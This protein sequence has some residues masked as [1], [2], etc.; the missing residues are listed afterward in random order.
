[1]NVFTGV[2][3][4]I[5]IQSVK[6]KKFSNLTA[7]QFILLLTYLLNAM[8]YS[9][10]QTGK[11]TNFGG[12]IVVHTGTELLV[13]QLKCNRNDSVGESDISAGIVAQKYYGCFKTMIV[14]PL[15]V[16]KEAKAVAKANNVELVDRNL[17]KQWLWK[18]LKE[19]WD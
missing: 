19:R 2:L 10:K 16:T 14:T 4:K 5:G 6:K 17:L 7:P 15:N 11:I 12:D 18:Y 8:N 9:V 1:M 13:V 3:G